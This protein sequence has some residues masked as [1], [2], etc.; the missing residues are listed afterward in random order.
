MRERGEKV[1]GQ[2]SAAL[3][4][5][6]EKKTLHCRFPPVRS[7]PKL[8]SARF[9]FESLL[10]VQISRRDTKE[11]QRGD[12]KGRERATK[13]IGEGKLDAERSAEERSHHR[14]REARLRP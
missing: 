4:C 14:S 1:L 7:L 6:D 5:H 9:F 10:K 2:R 12:G 13:S 3:E 8:F 11:R